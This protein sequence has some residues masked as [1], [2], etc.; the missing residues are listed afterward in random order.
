METIQRPLIKENVE[1]IYNG[2]LALEKNFWHMVQHKEG[3]DIML[4]EII[5]SP[6]GQML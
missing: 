2:I 4:S 3:E 1:R 6:K 5:Q